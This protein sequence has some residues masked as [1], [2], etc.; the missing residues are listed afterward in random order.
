MGAPRTLGSV[1][2]TAGTPTPAVLAAAG[3]TGTVITASSFKI[4]SGIATITLSTTLPANG[5]NGPNQAIQGYPA[6]PAGGQQVTLWGFT[7]ATYFNGKK[8][9][10]I[11]N[12]PSTNS[13]SFYFAHADVGSTSDAG[14]TAPSPFQHY[15]AIRLECSQTLGADFVY[16][17]DLNVSS[18]RY[19]AALSLT[20]QL[21]IEIASENIPPEAVFI[22]C[23]TNGDSVQTSLIY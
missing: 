17:G 14:K 5:Y 22:D 16:V 19:V 4:V 9:S 21:S 12:D 13:F 8:V 23:T 2:G 6:N 20:G 3:Y 7:T 11:Y 15:R 1:S 10:V 18:T